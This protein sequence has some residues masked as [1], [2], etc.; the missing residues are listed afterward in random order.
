MESPSGNLKEVFSAI[1]KIEIFSNKKPLK[2]GLYHAQF[3]PKENFYTPRV[4]K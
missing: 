3:I 4:N 1:F 2:V